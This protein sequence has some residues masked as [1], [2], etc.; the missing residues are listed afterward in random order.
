MNGHK[1]VDGKP[2]ECTKCGACCRW[3]GKVYLTPEDIQRLALHVGLAVDEFL[4]KYTET[5]ISSRVLK[6]K[7]DSQD[8]VFMDGDSCG[9]YGQHPSQCEKWPVKYDKR[10]PGFT[11]HGG[12]GHMNF[13][14]AVERV[15]KRFS[16]MR[17]WDQAVTDQFYKGLAAGSKEAEIASKALAGGV[18]P[19]AGMNSVKVAS[20]DDLFAFHRASDSH[21]IHKSTRDLWSIE[22]DKDGGVRITRLFD[23]DGEPVKG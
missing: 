18:D 12:E 4:S 14:E 16:A 23:N 2:F 15:N 9:V 21:L 1:M 17:E 8:C 20:I 19:T 3:Q 10:C 7:Q 6:N 13:K 11:T 5:D 22:T